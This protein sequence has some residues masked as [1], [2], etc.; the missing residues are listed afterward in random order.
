MFRLGNDNTALAKVNEVRAR[1]K[2]HA[3]PSLTWEQLVNERRVE[4]A[5]EETTYWDMFR[6][7]IAVEKMNGETNPIQAMKVVVNS[8]NGQTRYTISNMNRFPKRVRYFEEKQYYLP[9]PWD[10]IRYHGVSQ[11]PEWREM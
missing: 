9:I 3:L 4:L 2:M 10:E 1:A 11:N 5:F 8:S 6:W 7:G